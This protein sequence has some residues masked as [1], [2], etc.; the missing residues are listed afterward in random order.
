MIIPS[1]RKFPNLLLVTTRVLT[2]RRAY[3]QGFLNQ[4]F[5]KLGVL[6]GVLQ[7]GDLTTRGSY[8]QE[9]YNQG[10]LSP[11]VL[12]TRDSYNQGSYIQGFLQLGV[13]TTRGS[14][15]QGFYN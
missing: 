7:P 8:N 5:L 10:F 1:V 11:G 3:N 4:R 6:Q 14:N 12:T 13:L 2:T 15:N 9:S